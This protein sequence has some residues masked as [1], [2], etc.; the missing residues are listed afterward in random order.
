MGARFEKRSHERRYGND[1]VFLDIGGKEIYQGEMHYTIPEGVSLYLLTRPKKDTLLSLVQS[2]E[3]LDI[4]DTVFVSIEVR[5]G[6]AEM[7]IDDEATLILIQQFYHGHGDQMG[8]VPKGNGAG[9]VTIVRY[10]M[11]VL[12]ASPLRGYESVSS[13]AQFY[14]LRPVE[15]ADA[16]GA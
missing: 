8:V 6:K 7:R 13:G 5:D 9:S 16:L 12:S 11:G 14:L 3:K 4:P 10:P 1:L 2:A 15:V